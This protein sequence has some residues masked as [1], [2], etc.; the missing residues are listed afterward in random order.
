MRMKGSPWSSKRKTKAG[1]IIY[2][3]PGVVLKLNLHQSQI[4]PQD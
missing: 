3:F 1:T 4:F 2:E